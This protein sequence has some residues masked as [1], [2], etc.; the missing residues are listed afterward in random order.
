MENKKVILQP[1]E[2]ILMEK[3]W[4]N[5]PRTIMQLFRA[6]QEEQGWSKSTVNTMLGRMVQKGV[7]YYEEGEKAR[8]YYPAVARDDA[9]IVETEGLL[10]R[11]Y[12]GSVSM[13]LNTLIR[14]RNIS[15]E[16]IQE[17]YHILGEAVNKDD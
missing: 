7:I 1:S 4:G 3:L 5:P 17:L 16:E 11:I 6:L 2:W 15:D 9:A 12:Q 8:E 10:K 13:M 14:N